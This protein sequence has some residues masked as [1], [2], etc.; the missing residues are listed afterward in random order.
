MDIVHS[1]CLQERQHCFDDVKQ[2]YVAL[3]N[4]LWVGHIAGHIAG[5]SK[6]YEWQNI[7]IQS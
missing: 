7:C 5:H 3:P 1:T 4:R 2:C 6:E